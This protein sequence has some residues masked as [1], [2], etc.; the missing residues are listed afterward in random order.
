M[1]TQSI[2]IV[3]EAIVNVLKVLLEVMKITIM[4]II[5]TTTIF[6]YNMLDVS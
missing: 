6:H 4:I 2:V 1:G 3:V 5:R